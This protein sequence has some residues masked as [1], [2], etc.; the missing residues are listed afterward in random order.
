MP[1]YKIQIA[2]EGNAY[3][4]WQLQP[5]SCSIQGE[6]ERALAVFL[7]HPVRI[8][9][10]GRTDAGVHAK[11]QVA[12]FD[13][14]VLFEKRRLLYALASLLPSDIRVISL[15]EVDATF[16]AQYSAKRKIYSYHVW[17]EKIIDPFVRRTICYYSQPLDLDAIDQALKIL[18]GEHDFA[19]FA[20]Q[21]TPVKS[22]VRKLYRLE[23]FP[24]EGGFRIEFEGNGFLYKM[25]RN[26]MGLLLNIGAGKIDTDEI[27]DLLAKKDR[28]ASPS[29]AVASGL[30]LMQVIY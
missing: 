22:T 10:A 17:Q 6:I 12:H 2:Y 14:Q 24:A 19:S 23:R 5:N 8:S 15:E 1:R 16:H 20:N 4:G 21:G 13:T 30:C 25:V 3:C 29:A 11:G 9:G 26:L 27:M 18:E 7:K 28:R